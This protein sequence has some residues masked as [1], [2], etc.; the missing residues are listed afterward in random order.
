MILI[1]LLYYQ[2]E[3]KLYFDLAK[4]KVHNATSNISSKIIQ[5]HMSGEKSLSMIYYLMINIHF[6]YTMK[7]KKKF[8]ETLKIY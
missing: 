7:K 1:A 4:T 5:T 6:H 8:M 2:N 3:K